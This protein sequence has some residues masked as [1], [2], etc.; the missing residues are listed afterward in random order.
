MKRLI[1]LVLVLVCA[2]LCGLL[3][4][5]GAVS[6]GYFSDIYDV[7]TAQAAEMLR[8]LGVV[9]GVGGN[10]FNP[11][12]TL[13]RAEFCKM[14]LLIAGRGDEAKVQA[15]RVIFLDV[16]ATHWALGYINAAATAPQGGTA[17]VAGIGNGNF[18]PGRTITYGEAVTVLMRVLGYGN[19]DF[20][21]TGAWWSGYLSTAQ[22]LG[23]TASISRGGEE[24]ISRGEAARLFANLLS[25]N[26][27][28]GSS[29][30]IN[31]LAASVTADALILDVNAK[32]SDGS[33]GAVRTQSGTYKMANISAA[34]A[35]FAGLRASL[36]LDSAGRVLC[37]LPDPATSSRTFAVSEAKY[38]GIQTSDGD[39]VTIPAGTQVFS[40]KTIG[41]Y[42][43]VWINL[44]KGTVVTAYFDASGTLTSLYIPASEVTSAVVLGL[45]GTLADLTG[46]AS[47]YLVFKN[48]AAVSRSAAC[49][50]DVAVYD[51]AANAVTLS[52]LRISGTYSDV[53]PNLDTPARVTVMGIQ[54]ELLPEAIPMM[55]KFALG[56]RVTLL[57]T[58]S[59]RTGGSGGDV[60]PGKVA[61]VVAPSVAGS[62]A[63]GV[64]AF[65][66]SSA[67]ASR[68]V[69]V[70]LLDGLEI[71]GEHN[72]GYERTKQL[73]GSLV[74]VSSGAG[75]YLSVSSVSGST[76]TGNLDIAGRRVGDVALSETVR[77]FERVGTSQPVLIELDDITL[78]TVR[79][80][81]ILY[82]AKDTAG[83]IGCIILDDVTGDRY[84]YGIVRFKSITRESV[85]VSD[86]SG[87][88]TTEVIVTDSGHYY[89][90]YG[91]GQQLPNVAFINPMTDG[92]YGG[93]AISIQPS[94]GGLVQ[95][96]GSLNLTKLGTAAR[97]D[98]TTDEVSGQVYVTVG[99][100][101]YPV[102]DAVVC[103]NARTK[104]WFDDL[105]HARAYASTLTL[106][107]DRPLGEGGKVRMVVYE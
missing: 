1:A 95:P 7:P 42:E 96:A 16:P 70:T 41:S 46:R 74:T 71:A 57:L 63:I 76:V 35:M 49:T 26:P 10:S 77:V 45:T 67:S 11:G 84:T 29:T 33:S 98:F 31:T 38:T 99:G 17:L 59:V 54:F 68:H 44:G 52:D 61:A 39:F 90:E 64:A 25:V 92:S 91:K 47:D 75:D 12:G 87:G 34:P 13:T 27:K 100:V 89:I 14:A 55:S 43:T 58:P 32:A 22:G 103:Y 102:S 23:L 62:T 66:I 82:A 73:N 20:V 106:Y 107:I 86:G 101:R 8:M 37:I 72:M 15:N 30:Y 53:Y 69:S 28:D 50:Y 48:G 51:Q 19:S 93:M 2:A 18:A 79:Q 85:T 81:Q 24:T 9:E 21:S 104:N 83:K 40:G 88:T 5:A 94:A 105:S 6:G 4:A 60:T 78:A 97:S 80:S 56:D 36:A 65:D 3:P